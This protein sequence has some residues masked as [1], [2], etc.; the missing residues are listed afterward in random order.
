MIY[1]YSGVKSFEATLIVDDPGNCA[2]LAKGWYM[3][4]KNTKLP[5]DY[6]MII[7][8]IMGQTTIIKW[9]PIEEDLPALSSGYNLSV[10]SFKYNN[11]TVDKEIS[12]FLNDGQKFIYEAEI[13]EVDNAFE[14]LPKEYQFAATLEYVIDDDKEGK[15]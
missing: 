12:L 7:K 13:I 1:D 15:A 6:C 9:G 2:I 10:K 4:G 11:K 3:A 8:T 14:L 5:S